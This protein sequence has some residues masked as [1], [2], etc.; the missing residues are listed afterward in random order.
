MKQ[1]LL[2][3][4]ALILGSIPAYPQVQTVERN[5]RGQTGKD[6][7]V[8]AYLNVQPDCTSGTLPTIR[9]ITPPTHG[10]VIVKKAKVNA[11]N[12]KRCLALEVPAYVAIYHS[13]ANFSGSDTM[14]IEVKYLGGRTEIQN[15]KVTVGGAGKSI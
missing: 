3:A 7:Q 10:T 12:Y 6:V 9:L 14:T 5:A 11:T 15:I 1:L 13:E 4:V 8:G 2:A